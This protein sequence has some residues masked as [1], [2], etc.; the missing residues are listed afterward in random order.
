MRK[1][2]GAGKGRGDPARVEKLLLF[3]GIAE[4]IALVKEYA[5]VLAIERTREM[6]AGG[7]LGDELRQLMD[8]DPSGALDRLLEDDLAGSF[9]GEAED[10]VLQELAVEAGPKIAE[11]WDFSQSAGEELAWYIYSDLFAPMPLVLVLNSQQPEI[12]Q[13]V[14][15]AY[16][17]STGADASFVLSDRMMDGHLYL[18]VTDLSYRDLASAYSRILLCRQWLGMEPQDLREGAPPAVDG[19][20]ALECAYLIRTG[21]SGKEAAK[22]LGFRVYTGSNR[23]GSYP[24]FRKYAYCGLQ[25]EQ[26]LELLEAFM[27]S[28]SI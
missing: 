21:K 28:L 15:E 3:P 23:S 1:R 12:T 5:Y 18:D 19:K 25:I 13:R 7:E 8:A 26:R 24:L 22:Q 17:R 10:Q 20:K 4:A 27:E 6:A 11:L 14:R 16:R 9:I 2:T